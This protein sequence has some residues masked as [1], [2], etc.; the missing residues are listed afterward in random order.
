MTDGVD[1]LAAQWGAT[2]VG[3]QDDSGGVDDGCR[4]PVPLP[5]DPL[6]DGVDHLFQ[7]GGAPAVLD[8]ATGLLQVGPHQVQHGL[9]G[10][11]FYK[12]PHPPVGQYPVDAG[13]LSKS[14]CHPPAP[15]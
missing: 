6:G 14:R 7:A 3:V 10:V 15:E 12:L 8:G 1:G 2:Q 5:G 9:V 4:P 13:Q 11:I